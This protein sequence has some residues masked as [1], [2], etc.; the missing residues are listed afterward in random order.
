M[1]EIS[2]HQGL[3]IREDYLPLFRALSFEESEINYLA[4][5]VYDLASYLV[6]TKPEYRPFSKNSDPLPVKKPE[7]PNSILESMVDSIDQTTIFEDEMSEDEV[8][9]F[10]ESR[11]LYVH[12]GFIREYRKSDAGEKKKLDEVLKAFHSPSKEALDLFFIKHN[13]KR[14]KGASRKIF[15]FYFDGASGKRILWMYGRDISNRYERPS[16]VLLAF[17]R[18]HDEQ[19]KIAERI[20]TNINSINKFIADSVLEG[21]ANKTHNIPPYRYANIFD[22]SVFIPSLSEEQKKMVFC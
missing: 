17:V 19:G 22:V 2:N 8:D 20:C 12:P 3:G 9:E 10:V 15:K 18:E 21:P 13:N 5:V 1:Y 6:E 4:A 11:D 7:K 16:I 14:M